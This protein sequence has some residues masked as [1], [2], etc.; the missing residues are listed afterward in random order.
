MM[1]WMS[2][3]LTARRACFISA[4]Q[5]PNLAP[6]AFRVSRARRIE[7]EGTPSEAEWM[8]GP[9]AVADDDDGGEAKEAEESRKKPLHSAARS[10][11]VTMTARVQCEKNP[12][13]GERK[14]RNR[15]SNR[16]SEGSGWVA[17]AGA[18]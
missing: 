2:C 5:W 14:N 8:A 16:A 10:R 1:R 4:F 18:A 17:G 3:F 11:W 6:E 12:Q 13:E 15:G 7:A 9:A